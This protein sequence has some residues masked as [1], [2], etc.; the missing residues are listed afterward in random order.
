MNFPIGLLTTLP[1]HPVL[2][3]KN[4]GE[5]PKKKR[6][7]RTPDIMRKGGPMKDR[8]KYDRKPKHRREHGPENHD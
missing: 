8:S 2:F 3:I 6:P 7:G 5:P 4:V 1:P